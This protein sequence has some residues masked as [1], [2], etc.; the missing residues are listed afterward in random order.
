VK[1]LKKVMIKLKKENEEQ[2]VKC[3]IKLLKTY[4]R[5]KDKKC[6]S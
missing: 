2:N 3:S 5:D 1:N 4:I 6:Y